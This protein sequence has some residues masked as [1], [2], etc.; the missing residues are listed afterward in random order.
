MGWNRSET[1]ITK[2]TTMG[3]ALRT[4]DVFASEFLNVDLNVAKSKYPNVDYRYMVIPP[5]LLDYDLFM[6]F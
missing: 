5:L 6:T 3:M 1:N 4:L 2:F